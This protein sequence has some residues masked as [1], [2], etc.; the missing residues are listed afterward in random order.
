[1][2]ISISGVSRLRSIFL[3]HA[4]VVIAAIFPAMAASPDH[5]R[6]AW[7]IVGIKDGD[8]LTVILPG[9]PSPLNPI[10]VRLRSVDT[11]ESGGRARCASERRLA[12]SA[13][14]FT[15]HAIAAAKRIEFESPSWDKY[16]GRID[17]DVW[18]DGELLS[19]QLIASGLARPYD[20][21][22]RASWC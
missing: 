5:A 6:Y 15:R 17:A 11:P 1:L 14:R 2:V 12:E 3:A 9:L 22:K 19:D 8:T 18:V 4:I 13:T 20:G 16:G 7:Q 10:A 21:G